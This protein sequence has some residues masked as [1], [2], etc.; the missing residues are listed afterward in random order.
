MPIKQLQNPKSIFTKV[1]ATRRYMSDG[2]GSE[3]NETVPSVRESVSYGEDQGGFFDFFKRLFGFGKKNGE[4]TGNGTETDTG[5]DT[6]TGADTS[7]DVLPPPDQTTGTDITDAP[8]PSAWDRPMNDSEFITNIP[9]EQVGQ[10]IFNLEKND[11]SEDVKTRPVFE[12]HSFMPREEIDEQS[13]MHLHSFMGLRYTKLNR[14]TGRLERKRAKIGYG[15]SGSPFSTAGFLDDTHTQ[16][17]ISTETAISMDRFNSVVA[18]VDQVAKNI[19]AQKRGEKDGEGFS[20]FYNVISNNCNNFVEHMARVAG[21]TVPANLHHSWLGPAG[22][23]KQL[24]QAAEQGQQGDTRFFQGGGKGWGQMS[25]ANR[26]QFLLGYNGEARRALSVDGIKLEEDA[27]FRGLITDLSVNAALLAQYLSED[28]DSLV[29]TEQ[30]LTD[31]DNFLND[32]SASVRSVVEYHHKKPH[33]RMNISALKVE[34]LAA[35]VRNTFLAKERGIEDLTQTELVHSLQNPTNAEKIADRQRS[36]FTLTNA[37]LYKPKVMEDMANLDTGD[38]QTGPAK[39]LLLALG[40]GNIAEYI[41]RVG[42][43]KS[44]REA[45][46]AMVAD[47]SAKISAN[48][49]ALR[50]YLKMYLDVRRGNSSRQCATLLA[51]GIIEAICMHNLSKILVDTAAFKDR[52]TGEISEE[53]KAVVTSMEEGFINPYKKDPNSSPSMRQFIEGYR[54]QLTGAR[55]IESALLEQIEAIRN[56]GD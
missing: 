42:G 22:A 10:P 29:S 4:D 20:G 37:A 33:P 9:N 26:L 30:D 5:S 1:D 13:S 6:G 24:A 36:S 41:N 55:E 38:S 51:S 52:E 14:K 35:V 34:A 3:S 46:M 50:P 18:S 56:S 43:D 19:E 49:P 11:K 7:V 40:I 45:G 25:R 8:Q 27:D 28:A 2:F 47:L 53:D 12:T 17:D 15:D 32:V 48:A 31:L 16:A 23:Y 39:I 54:A 44:S 21:A